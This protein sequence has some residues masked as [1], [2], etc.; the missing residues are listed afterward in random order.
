[1][2]SEPHDPPQQLLP[3]QGLIVTSLGLEQISLLPT[4][5]SPPWPQL[6][7]LHLYP[8]H[9]KASIEHLD[10]HSE[11]AETILLATFGSLHIRCVEPAEIVIAYA[12]FPCRLI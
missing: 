10:V 1:M 7:T 5:I 8:W 2:E 3:I 6:P 12:I 4:L 11:N 9:E